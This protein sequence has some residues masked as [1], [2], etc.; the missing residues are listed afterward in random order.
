ME[1]LSEILKNTSL[2]EVIM[3]LVVIY[4]LFRPD[5]I[6]RI[7]KFK[8]GD[9]EVEL[10]ELK[11][12]IAKGNEKITELETELEHEKRQFEELLDSF[13]ANVP[14]SEL[15]S[16]RQS[17]KAQARNL[18]EEESLKKYLKKTATHEELYAAAVGIREKRPVSLFPDL[19]GLLDD[20]STQKDLGGYRLNTIWTLTSAVHKILISI[21]RDGVKPTPSKEQLSKCENMLKRLDNNPR[22]LADRPDKPMKGIKGPIKYSLDWL[23]KLENNA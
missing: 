2:W 12:E 3:L 11:K 4:L 23:K 22:V 10:S 6:N 20:L 1:I 16:I 14:L 19:I 17:I 15:K 9:F 13:D 8:V 7:T 5:L 18:D 21:V